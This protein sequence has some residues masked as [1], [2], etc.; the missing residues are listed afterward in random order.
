MDLSELI[1]TSSEKNGS[2]FKLYGL[3]IATLAGSF[4]LISMIP[5]LRS[6][7]MGEDGPIELLSAAGYFFCATLLFIVLGK[8]AARYWHVLVVLLALG[9]R[10]LDFNSRFTQISATKLKFYI[11]PEVPAFQKFLAALVLALILYSLI[12]VIITFS[13]PFIDSLKKVESSAVCAATG[14]VF[15]V[16]AVS[17]DGLDNRMAG[18]GLPISGS[19][20]QFAENAEEL[21]ELGIPVMFAL[22]VNVARG[23]LSHDSDG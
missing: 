10:E 21:L 8:R 14:L 6:T 18:M 3:I 1:R 20:A 23:S 9:C 7:L 15:L 22:G 17:L 4:I 13:R 19:V 2:F 16:L 5:D 12:H 11:N